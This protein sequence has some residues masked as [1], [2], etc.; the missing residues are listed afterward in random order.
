MCR[1]KCGYGATSDAAVTGQHRYRAAGTGPRG[2]GTLGSAA[3]EDVAVVILMNI[4]N[5]LSSLR[6]SV[7]FR[8]PDRS[9]CLFGVQATFSKGQVQGAF[10]L[11]YYSG[12][13][14][15]KK[16]MI[17]NFSS[18][19]LKIKILSQKNLTLLCGEIGQLNDLRSWWLKNEKALVTYLFK[20]SYVLM[21]ILGSF[22]LDHGLQGIITS[23]WLIIES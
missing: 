12:Q 10:W 20:S 14:S 5:A 23:R 11:N 4:L 13:N 21:T 16:K 9:I 6:N 3:I 22:C 18:W 7:R 8:G 1:G 19:T 15:N 2:H 17:S